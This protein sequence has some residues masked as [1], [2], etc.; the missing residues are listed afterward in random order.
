MRLSTAFAALS[1]TLAVAASARAA[2]VLMISIDGLRPGDVLEA[3]ARGATVPN[4][5]RLVG[6]G[7]YADGV[8]NA[9]PTVTYPNHATLVTGVWPKRH[10]IASNTTFDPLQKNFGGWYWYSTDIKVPTLWDAVHAAGGRTA[11]LDWP[12]TVGQASIDDNIPEYWR[13]QTADDLKVI[14]ALATRGLLERVEKDSGV[15]LADMVAETPEADEEKAKAAAAIIADNHPAFFTLHFSSLDRARTRLRPRLASAYAALA[16]IDAAIGAL[17]ASARKSEP[18]LVVAVVS[19]H[20]FAP[21]QHDIDLGPAFVEAGLIKLD[22]EGK[23]IQWEATPWTSGGSAAVVLARR[24]D[25]ALRERVKA[26]LDRLAADPN[27][28]IGRV[29]GREEIAALGGERPDADFFVDAKIGYEFGSH[30][31]GPL[32]QAPAT[33]GMHGYFPEH[34]EMHSTLI[35]EGPGIAHR[36][37]GEVDMRDI[38]PTIAKVLGVGLPSA[39]GKALF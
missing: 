12:T 28:G 16:R 14:H 8:K 27:S 24:D 38:A 29:I 11:S 35:V 15:K 34:P 23:P 37:L 22:A 36:D 1:A 39:D 2:P 17:V 31:T 30:L 20:G 10:G 13:A 5:K 26:L 25:A 18:D 7:A 32:V 33:K 21:V 4:L 9:L 3:D 19:D 6:A